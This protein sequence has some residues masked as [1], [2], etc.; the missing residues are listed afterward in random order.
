MR[1]KQTLRL[2][3]AG[4]LQ[5][6]EVDERARMVRGRSIRY[7]IEASAD[8]LINRSFVLRLMRKPVESLSTTKVTSTTPSLV[9]L[10]S[11]LRLQRPLFCS[12]T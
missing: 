3:H 9:V 8:I 6:S 11:I 2:V 10:Y 5:I 7:L 12:K 1:G 4:K